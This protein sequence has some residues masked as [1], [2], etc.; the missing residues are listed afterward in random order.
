M[1]VTL[2]VVEL[3]PLFN[4]VLSCLRWDV[5]ITASDGFFNLWDG[6]PLTLEPVMNKEKRGP[7][8]S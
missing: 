7:H 5:E 4:R 2:P 3:V 6:T 8:Y 1:L